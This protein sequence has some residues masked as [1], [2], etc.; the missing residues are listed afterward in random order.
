MEYKPVSELQRIL[1]CLP[2][3]VTDAFGQGQPANYIPALAE[4]NPNKF[5]MAVSTVE[6]EDF[7]VGDAGEMFSIQSISKVFSLSLAISHMGEELFQ[8]VG[9]EPSGTTFNSLSQLEYENGIPRNPFI[10]AGALVVSDALLEYVSSPKQDF[11]S[12]VPGQLH[13]FRTTEQSSF[14]RCLWSHPASFR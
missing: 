10:N 8:R 12:F 6:G 4:V 1:A 3:A 13:Q 11:L 5:G 7:T 14:F 9:V 2:E